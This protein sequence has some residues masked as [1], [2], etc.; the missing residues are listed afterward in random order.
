MLPSILEVVNVY[1]WVSVCNGC[2]IL[3][4][5]LLKSIVML[6]LI[7]ENLWRVATITHAGQTRWMILHNGGQHGTIRVVL[8]TFMNIR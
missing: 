5:T 7:Y 8:P 2:D 4:R 3:H 1:S 6:S